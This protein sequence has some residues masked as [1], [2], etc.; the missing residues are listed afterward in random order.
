MSASN[1]LRTARRG[2]E[3]VNIILVGAGVGVAPTCDHGNVLESC[4]RLGPGKVRLLFKE[5]YVKLLGF[6][7]GASNE[8]YAST[9]GRRSAA[10]GLVDVKARTID[11]YLQE[12]DHRRQVDEISDAVA[13][14]TAG[15]K[16]ATATTVAPQ[17]ILA[18]ALL[19]GGKTALLV[20][21][22]NITFTTA[23]G[24]ASDAPATAT[25]TGTDINGDA[26]TETVN[27]SQTA[28]TVEGAKA[29]RTI[30]KIEYS[31][32]DGTG[33]TIAIGFG[34]KFGLSKKIRTRAG[35]LM[36]GK[37]IA[38][39]AVVTNGTLVAPGTSAPNGTYAPNADP[40]G[41]KDFSI[42]YEPDG[43]AK[44]LPL[45]ESLYLTFVL[46]KAMELP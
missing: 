37:E 34:K 2:A 11:V 29:F 40:D 42:E 23:G 1:L 9:E 41:A 13:P 17:T 28:A 36:F 33:A 7:A 38:N 32:A 39:G 30:T 4:T 19:A 44:D 12:G 20:H 5:A 16:A 43:N 18:A 26:L 25:I 22:R 21:P 45:G 10:L 14:A 24:T 35:A 31:A 27:I 3:H 8:D 6:S 15:L 46:T